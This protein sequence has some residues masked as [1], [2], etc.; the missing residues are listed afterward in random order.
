MKRQLIDGEAPTVTDLVPDPLAPSQ[1]A[2]GALASKRSRRQSQQVWAAA[3]GVAL[4]AAALAWGSWAH[5]QAWVTELFPITVA[6]C[7][8]PF[9]LA[10]HLMYGAAHLP[11]AERRISYMLNMGVP[12]FLLIL[13]FAL[14]QQPYSRGA[15]ALVLTLEGLWLFSL[16]A[17]RGEKDRLRLFVLDEA[18]PSRLLEQLAGAAGPGPVP[19]EQIEWVRWEDGRPLPEVDGVLWSD[20]SPMDPHALDKLATLKCLHVRLY[21]PDA[22]A[23][24]LSGRVS[25]KAIANPLWQPDGNPAYDAVKRFLDVVAVLALAPLWVPLCGMVAIA[26]RLDS[27]GPALF[28]QIRTGLHG[29]AF[30][31]WKFRTMVVQG[32]QAEAQFAQQGDRRVT[33]LGQLLRKSRLDEV[34][35][36]VNVLWGHMSLIGPRPEQQA[37]VREFAVSIPS[38]PYRHLVRPGLTGWAQVC[39]GYAADEDS[40]TIKLSY[41]LYYVKHYS[42]A[43]DLLIVAKTVRTIL[44]GFGAR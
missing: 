23:E 15:I 34:P 9:A 13:A 31:I 38:Y 30:R 44:T 26:V 19:T 7:L 33:R 17:F 36:L 24:S 2:R 1:G 28:S 3:G 35:Q 11:A 18:S 29:R 27:S 39:Q 22:V 20:A 5:Q 16:E 12:F 43:L 41:D 25:M 21:S 42:L 37:F 32:P 40:T 14:M 4:L 10:M 8:L 6:W